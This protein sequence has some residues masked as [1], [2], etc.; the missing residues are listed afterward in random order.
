MGVLYKTSFQGAL[1]TLT[2][3]VMHLFDTAQPGGPTGLCKFSKT[4]LFSGLLYKSWKYGVIA[5]T[6][7]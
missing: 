6:K 5:A 4:H 7:N 1:K 3:G 2:F